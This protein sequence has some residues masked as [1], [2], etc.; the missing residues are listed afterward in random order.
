[1][2]VRTYSTVRYSTCSECARDEGWRR[3]KRTECSPIKVEMNLK[4][5]SQVKHSQEGC[6]GEGWMTPWGRGKGGMRIYLGL[7]VCLPVSVSLLECMI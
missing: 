6:L 7:S 5:S 2:L 1:M 3:V 4:S